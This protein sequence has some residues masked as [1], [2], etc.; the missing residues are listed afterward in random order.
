MAKDDIMPITESISERYD[1]AEYLVKEKALVV[2][3]LMGEI[4]EIGMNGMLFRYYQTGERIKQSDELTILVEKDGFCLYK[5]PYQ[6]VEDM[7]ENDA[8]VSNP[9]TGESRRL[10]RVKFSALTKLQ[11]CQLEYFIEN[12]TAKNNKCS[13]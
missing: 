3:R 9:E 7:A 2:S 4:V 6:T 11:K 5:I 8:A 1:N 12:Y 10:H 13:C